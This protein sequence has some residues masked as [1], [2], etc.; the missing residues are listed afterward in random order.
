MMKSCFHRLPLLLILIIS[1]FS[2]SSEQL[3]PGGK[4]KAVYDGGDEFIYNLWI[5]DGILFGKI[6]QMDIRSQEDSNPLCI[7]CKGERK[8]QPW[9]G[10]TVITDVRQENSEEWG[11]GTILD[12]DSGKTYKCKIKIVEGGAKIR[13][14]GY[15]GFFGGTEI[16]DRVGS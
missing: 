6:E 4:W 14:R 10:M 13:I 1:P 16:W 15:S 11:G 12:L 3:S 9:L 5:E 2:Y 8:N 7:K